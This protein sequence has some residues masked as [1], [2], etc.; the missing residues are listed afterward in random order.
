M[1]RY[2]LPLDAVPVASLLVQP[3]GTI[4]GAS[5]A[6]TRLLGD[7]VGQSITKLAPQVRWSAL[8]Q[9]AVGGDVFEDGIV[10][11]REGEQ[12][13]RLYVNQVDLEGTKFAWMVV[14]ER[15]DPK[16][17]AN[18]RLESLGLVA[19]GIAHDFN[20]LLVGV[21]AEASAAR[22]EPALTEGTREALRRIEA[23]ARRMAQLTRQLLAFAGRAQF[24][25]IP[26]DADELLSE[27]RDSL[28]RSVR[29][30]LALTITAGAPRAVVEAD[31]HLLRQVLANLVSNASDA[32]VSRVDVNTR[33]ISRDG[34][35]YWQLEVADDGLGIDASALPRIFEPFFSTKSGHHGLGLSAVH[36]IVRRLGGDVEVDTRGA[37]PARGSRFRVRLP[38]ALGVEPAPR[39]QELLVPSSRLTGMRALV[40]DDE[41]SVRATVRRLLERRGATVVVAADGNEAEARLRD[42]Q[43]SLVITD[44]AMPGATGWEVLSIARATQP[45]VR[46]VLMSGYTEKLR[47]TGSEDE[48]DAFLEKP[49]TAK[50]LDA[51]VDEV[52][53]GR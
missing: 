8:F 39:S 24:V 16:D 15:A 20:N 14:I 53:K 9:G 2:S 42:E 52:L 19:G 30:E 17:P 23:S 32:A 11:T 4:A 51:T 13:S 36:G 10:A 49:F 1:K 45:G 48:P 7:V 27:S 12:T 38:I 41:P 34:M 6:A 46:V 29:T 47:G 28:T 33:L 18:Q 40:A 26:V 22:E 3:D 5:P 44:V 50:G 35:S 37:G 31:P 25:T 43:F 21:L